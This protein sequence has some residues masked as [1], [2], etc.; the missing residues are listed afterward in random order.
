MRTGTKLGTI[1]VIAALLLIILE[2]NFAC[3]DLAVTDQV[4]QAKNNEFAD[5]VPAK[6]ADLEGYCDIAP[7]I[8]K[9][10]RR[11]EGKT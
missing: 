8:F 5:V 10:K 11:N 1:P 2:S 6:K 9:E 7:L 3:G 4:T